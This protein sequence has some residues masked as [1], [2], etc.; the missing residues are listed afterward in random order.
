M[1]YI[2]H[3]KSINKR[4][5]KCKIALIKNAK[6]NLAIDPF[7]TNPCF[8][9]LRLLLHNSSILSS[10]QHIRV[11][12]NPYYGTSYKKL[13]C[14]RKKERIFQ[15]AIL[16]LFFQFCNK[17]INS[18]DRERFILHGGVRKQNNCYC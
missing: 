15:I 3:K 9:M 10:C 1:Q 2:T 6:N 7:K 13:Y 18:I 17:V 5:Q 8:P 4:N 11:R 14:E 12:Q 16:L